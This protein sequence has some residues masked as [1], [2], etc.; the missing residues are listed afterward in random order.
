VHCRNGTLI[1][2]FTFMQLRLPRDVE[3][4]FDGIC[5]I[6]LEVAAKSK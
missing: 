4:I 1:L 2:D 3:K 5:Q 6:A